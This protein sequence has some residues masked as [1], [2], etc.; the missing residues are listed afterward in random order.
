MREAIIAC[1]NILTNLEK[2][3]VEVRSCVSA[4]RSLKREAN[5]NTTYSTRVQELW[6]M[7]FT[8]SDPNEEMKVSCSHATKD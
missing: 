2:D 4:D 8:F 6:T 3:Y 1:F 5:V 7:D